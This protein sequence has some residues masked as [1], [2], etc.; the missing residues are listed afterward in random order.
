MNQIAALDDKIN[1]EKTKAV[2]DDLNRLNEVILSLRNLI[3]NVESAIDRNYYNCYGEGENVKIEQSG[4]V[5]VYIVSGD[6]FRDYL[7]NIYG[8]SPAMLPSVTKDV[9]FNKVDIFG[10]DW[11]GRFGYPFNDSA[12]N[13]PDFSFSGSFNCLN[14]ASM[15]TGSS[16][17]TGI[18]SN[19]IE[20]QDD[21]GN[22]LRFNLGS[23]SRLESTL[24]VPNVGQ[25]FFYSGVPG[26]QGLNLYGGTCFEWKWLTINLSYC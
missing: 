21:Q 6:H 10:P 8:I 20:A 22:I 26:N 7:Q 1:V 5:S 3:P 4:N 2:D 15:V 18:G 13:S 14:P 16:V 24:R 25:K 23:C 17:I 12:F 9:A 19:F 11:A